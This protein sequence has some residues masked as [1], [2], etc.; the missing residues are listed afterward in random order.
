MFG[1]GF[2]KKIVALERDYGSA[3]LERRRKIASELHVACAGQKNPRD[4]LPLL[5]TMLRDPDSEIGEAAVFGLSHCRDAGLARLRQLLDDP[6]PAVRERACHA[7]GFMKI[8]TQPARHG[9]LAALADP[10]AG[11]RGRAAFALGQMPDTST[12]TVDAL[13]ALACDPDSIPRNC[14]LHA[15]GRIGREKE[16]RRAVGAH[17]AL[18]LAA[19]GDADAEVR[20]AA[21]YAFQTTDPRGT[22]ALSILLERLLVET[23]E[24]TRQEITSTLYWVAKGEDMS[25]HLPRLL[26]IAAARK[27]ARSTVFSLCSALGS[28]AAAILPL[29]RDSMTG[30]GALSAIEALHKITGSDAEVVPALERVLEEGAFHQRFQAARKILEMTGRVEKIVA[31][32]ERALQQ[33]PDEP[34]MFI[35]EIGQPLAAV[36]PAL[37]RAIDE[38]FGESDWDVMWNLTCAMAALQSAE[39]AAVTALSKALSHP[40]DRVQYAAIEG[41]AHAGPAAR[42]ALPALQRLA[43]QGAELAETAR[44]T[45]RAIE[46]RPN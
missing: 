18:F 2:R 5:E 4:A 22:H 10:A 41:L 31:M 9:L 20:W 38:N 26:E 1:S 24:R 17:R 21:C 13:A 46:K 16:G 12:A 33:S 8:G 19:L 39:P 23:T 15:L 28:R 3:S 40:S 37:A 7:L 32:L 44:A 34:G 14:A 25:M 45:I 43:A 35:Q 27:E 36:A 11:V 6:S 42:V 29:V 30:E